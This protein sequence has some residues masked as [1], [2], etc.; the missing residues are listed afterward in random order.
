MG[1]SVQPR[2]Q[3]F[4]KGYGP[5]L[6]A[7]NLDENI[8]ENISKNLS[9]IYSQK[10]FDHAK[11]SAMDALIKSS[12]RVIQKTAESTSDFIT[13]KIADRITKVSKNSWQ[14]HSETVTNEHNNETNVCIYSYIRLSVSNTLFLRFP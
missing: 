9:G 6:F 7:K 8:C 4:A 11:K 1:Y 5:L 13:N 12:K 14:N 2:D 10:L 3:I